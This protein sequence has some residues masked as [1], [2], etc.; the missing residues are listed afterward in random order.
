MHSKKCISP[1]PPPT[2]PQP[3]SL[4]KIYKER[5]EKAREKKREE[6]GI[7]KKICPPKP[8]VVPPP[9]ECIHPLKRCEAVCIEKI[10]NPDKELKAKLCGTPKTTFITVERIPT[11][12][13]RCDAIK[14]Q[15]TS[16]DDDEC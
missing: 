1:P 14:A 9:E 12:E 2:P 16:S 6:E 13:A 8:V 3:S 15:T 10:N 4:C 5:K 7:P 11:G